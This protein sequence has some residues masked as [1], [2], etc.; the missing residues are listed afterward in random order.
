LFNIWW[1]RNHA[2]PSG[3]DPWD[4][5][6]LEW[7]IP[8]PAPAYN[9]DVVPV[10]HDVDDFWHRKYTE[11]E[12]GRLVRIPSGGSDEASALH[13]QH[14]PGS[15]DHGHG[16]GHGHGIHMPS[17]SYFPALASVGIM[18]V[19]YGAIYHWWIGAIGGVIL[20]AGVFGWGNEPLSE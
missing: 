8:S 1:S 13:E 19:G 5:R 15:D 12:Q 9:F 20:L 18:I 4:A 3:D 2:E 16:D 14:E 11:D 10:V 17:P 7:S 6:S